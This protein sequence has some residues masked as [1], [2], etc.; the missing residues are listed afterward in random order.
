MVWRLEYKKEDALAV[1]ISIGYGNDSSYRQGAEVFGTTACIA[2]A[3]SILYVPIQRTSPYMQRLAY[4]LYRHIPVGV[5]FL[6]E[7]YFRWIIRLYLRPAS[8]PTS[9]SGGLQPGAR[10]F[11]DNLPFKFG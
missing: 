11:P 5:E 9:R 6:G 8:E 3:G 10:P 2:R 4:L 7:S 1:G